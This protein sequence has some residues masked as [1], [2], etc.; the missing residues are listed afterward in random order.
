MSK[1]IFDLRQFVN[2]RMVTDDLTGRGR[3]VPFNPQ[4]GRSIDPHHELN[5]KSY[6]EAVAASQNVGFVLTAKDPYY[7]FDIDDAIGADGQWIP[8]AVTLYQ[9]FV[10]AGAAAEV[11]QSGKG[12][13]L[14]GK[15]DQ[16]LTSNRRNKFGKEL[17]GKNWLE[18]YT[19]KRFMALGQGFTG[20]F[21][22]TTG[23]ILSVVPERA[24]DEPDT[25]DTSGPRP[26]Y[27]G[28][29]DDDEL[30]RRL[31]SSRGS[32]N[33]MFGATAT[34]GQLFEGNLAV[35]SKL[36]PSPSGDAFDRS[37]AD[38]ALL[39]HLAFWTGCDAERMDR[40]FRRSA[41]VRDKWLKRE[42]YRRDSIE[43]ACKG[44]KQVHNTPPIECATVVALDGDV[45]VPIAANEASAATESSI[46]SNTCR[47]V[48]RAVAVCG[49]VG[50]VVAVRRSAMGNRAHITCIASGKIDLQRIRLEA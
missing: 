35:L 37:S 49:Q 47:T 24:P 46:A 29:T 28:P 16:L 42:D 34:P 3:K 18:F 39:G 31:C 9:Q 8:E 38:A 25:Y 40:I 6:D 26:D 2:W 12:M 41:L 36:F 27:T 10:A 30:I 13:H 50:I 19:Q 23:L 32:M 5:W 20:P 21:A 33:A 11:S 4:T 7:L 44:C 1:T 17:R 45:I 22:D 15:C 14:V 43:F 48:R